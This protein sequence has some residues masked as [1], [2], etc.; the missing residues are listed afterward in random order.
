MGIDTLTNMNHF[1]VDQLATILGRLGLRQH[2]PCDLQ[3]GYVWDNGDRYLVPVEDTPQTQVALDKEVGSRSRPLR[4]LAGASTDA[5]ALGCQAPS[6]E[7]FD[8]PSEAEAGSRNPGSIDDFEDFE[9]SDYESEFADSDIGNT[10]EEPGEEDDKATIDQDAGALWPNVLGA[11]SYLEDAVRMLMLESGVDQEPVE[12][13][14]FGGRATSRQRW[15][16]G[17]R[18]VRRNGPH[19]ELANLP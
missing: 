8:V 15:S 14:P 5:V 9:D 12:Q 2:P 17:C 19:T 16:L 13:A 3:L 7:G 18:S 11:R 6:G 4:G 10:A 1:S